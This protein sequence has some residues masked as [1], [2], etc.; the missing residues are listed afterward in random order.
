MCIYIYIYIYTQILRLQANGKLSLF[1]VFY[2]YF[3]ADELMCLFRGS[4]HKEVEE[5]VGHI[6]K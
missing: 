1:A 5:S 3:P 2:N 6:F 4:V